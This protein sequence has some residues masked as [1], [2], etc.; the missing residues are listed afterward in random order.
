MD[1][2]TKYLI[3]TEITIMPDDTMI[4]RATAYHANVA[5][6][7][8]LSKKLKAGADNRVEALNMS[9]KLIR[10]SYDFIAS[11]VVSDEPIGSSRPR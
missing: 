8:H 10:I 5:A 3:T 9:N 1:K 6:D 11:A 7:L 2:D 4:G